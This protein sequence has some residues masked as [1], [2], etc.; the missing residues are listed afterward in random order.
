MGSAF[1][2]VRF[3]LFFSLNVPFET[4][5]RVPRRGFRQVGRM[6]NRIMALSLFISHGVRGGAMQCHS[7]TYLTNLLNP[8]QREQEGIRSGSCWRSCVRVRS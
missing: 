1:I 8:R 7:T 3:L 5:G 2:I 4:F 6:D